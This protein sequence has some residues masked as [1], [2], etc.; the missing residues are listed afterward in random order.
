MLTYHP[1][2]DRARDTIASAPAFS[3]H[4]FHPTVHSGRTATAL[5]RFA[6]ALADAD[7]RS[8]D[9]SEDLRADMLAGCDAVRAVEER[10]AAEIAGRYPC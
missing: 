9:G 4:R 8:Y 7:T 2:L 1:D 10:N 5:S 3:S 6:T